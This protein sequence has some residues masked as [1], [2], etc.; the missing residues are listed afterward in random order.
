MKSWEAIRTKDQVPQG[1]LELTVLPCKA[2]NLARPRSECAC[3]GESWGAALP[4]QTPRGPSD[5]CDVETSL[6]PSL[7]DFSSGLDGIPGFSVPLGLDYSDSS[8]TLVRQ[9]ASVPQTLKCMNPSL[10]FGRFAAGPDVF[11]VPGPDPSPDPEPEPVPMPPS[12]PDP[13]LPPSLPVD[14]LPVY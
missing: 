11:P 10:A 6:Q 7:R 1:R 8:E 9:P 2:R 5:I 4:S 13:G 14:P 12:D 3:L